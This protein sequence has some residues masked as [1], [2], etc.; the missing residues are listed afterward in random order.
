MKNIKIYLFSAMVMAFVATGCKKPDNTRPVISI[1][2]PTE[3]QG[4]PQGG[5]IIFK[6]TFSDDRAL[7]SY[8][9]DV[10]GAFDGHGHETQTD[11]E[12]VEF[13]IGELSGEQEIVERKIPVPVTAKT[14]P[15]HF[16][17]KCIDEAGNETS[18]GDID[19]VILQKQ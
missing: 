9:I 16:L 13:F 17:V 10:H 6:A 4:F 12:W 19:I 8:K 7:S 1:E 2:A 5:E 14:G 11:V 3:G 18:S 15:Y